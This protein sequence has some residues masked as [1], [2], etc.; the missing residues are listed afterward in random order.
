[1]IPYR[2]ALWNYFPSRNK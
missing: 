1:L 2:I